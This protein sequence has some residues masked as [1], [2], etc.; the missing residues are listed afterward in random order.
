MFKQLLIGASFGAILTL[1]ACSNAP[2]T[3]QA[4]TANSSQGSSQNVAAQRGNTE[5]PPNFIVLIGDDMSVETLSCF[6]VGPRSAVTP[7]L[8][9]LCAQGKRFPNFWT[10]PV[11]SPTRAAILSG[12]YGFRNGVGTPATSG[13]PAMPRPPAPSYAT[14]ETSVGSPRPE[15]GM[16]APAPGLKANS[17]T[18]PKALKAAPVSY[19]TYAFGKW[20]LA[21]PTN[22]G[23][24][25]PNLAG[26]DH[27]HGPVRGGGVPSY[28]HWSEVINGQITDGRTGWADTAKVDDALEFMRGRDSENPFLLWMAFNSPHTPFHL[29]PV[30]LLNSDAK[31]LDPNAI[32]EENQHEYYLAM[33]EALD[34]E[35]G[36]LLEN[37]PEENMENTYVVFIGDNGTP[38]QVGTDPFDFYHAK[39]SLTQGGVNVPFFVS[40]PDIAPGISQS[41]SNSVDIY[42]T[43]ADLSGAE[44]PQNAAQDSVSLVPALTA[45]QD[46]RDFAYAD[47]FG[48]VPRG[49]VL[50]RA[51]RNE[52]HKLIVETDGLEKLFALG[53][54]PYEKNDLMEKGGLSAADEAAL[55]TLRAK[56][57][58]LKP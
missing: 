27:Y 1:S 22:G 24:D 44:I 46:V 20:H 31:N 18:L 8:D 12:Q 17:F 13:I 53:V 9:K 47:V 3:D 57:E 37:M 2:S 43:F 55:T 41:L 21:D 34:T 56:L 32:N 54:D 7:N 15:P 14:A 28:F 42:A 19:D 39:G 29:P 45:N 5:Q 10:Q 50:E 40:G 35:I 48:L 49:I 38:E 30:N 16:M 11:C 25:H 51:I 33:I 36:R 23:K 26:F 52:S 58:E 6:N 4:S